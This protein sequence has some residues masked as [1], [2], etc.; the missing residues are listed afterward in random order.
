MR[1]VA[2]QERGEG[3]GA[4]GRRSVAAENGPHYYTSLEPPFIYSAA[5]RTDARLISESATAI[6]KRSHASSKA[7]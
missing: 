3:G 5:S 6:G 2:T 4:S 1:F 7:V